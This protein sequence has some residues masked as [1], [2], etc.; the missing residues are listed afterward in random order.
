MAAR[1][2]VLL[3]ALVLVLMLS[4]CGGSGTPGINASPPSPTVGAS[5]AAGIPVTAVASPEAS[6]AVGA[7]VAGE[8]SPQFPF[9]DYY[10]FLGRQQ[11]P[12]F[13]FLGRQ[14]SPESRFPG[15]HKFWQ[16]QLR[17]QMAICSHCDQLT[18]LRS[19]VRIR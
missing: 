15:H 6:P 18:P 19:P 16:R 4:S 14:Q 3:S 7:P 13:R 9:L 11:S 10:R 17:E 8:R 2:T 12:Q 5:P 1:V